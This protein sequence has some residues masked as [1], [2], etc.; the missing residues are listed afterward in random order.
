MQPPTLLL[1][2]RDNELYQS[3]LRQKPPVAL[4][5]LRA[6]DAATARILAPQADIVLGEPERIAAILPKATRLRWAQSTFAGIDCLLAPDLRHDYLLTNIRGVFGPLMS[7]YVFAHLLS[8]TRHLPLYR[9]QQRQQQWHPI[10]YVPLSQRRILILGTGSIGQH[11]AA[12][13]KQFGM[14]VWG[15]NRSG[16]EVAGFDDLYQVSALP[17]LLPQA[18]VIVSVLPATSETHHLLDAQLLG[19]CKTSA[20]LFNVGRGSAID[21]QAL[22]E[23]LRAGRPAAAVL[24]VFEEEPLPASHPLWQLPNLII[25]PHNSAWSLPEQVLKIFERNLVR[26]VSE[27]PLEHVVDFSQGY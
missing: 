26:F 11:L 21:T 17:R 23:A 14:E 9:E 4:R 16:R 15:V 20:I 25:T 18:D 12:T 19:L 3:L 24:D 8:L 6:D 10:P 5:L 7:E 22:V 27:E 2:S 13:A 1:T